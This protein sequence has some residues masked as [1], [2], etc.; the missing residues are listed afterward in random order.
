MSRRPASPKCVGPGPFLLLLMVISGGSMAADAVQGEIRLRP[1]REGV[2]WVGQELEINL[3]LLSTG[4]SFGGQHFNL[5]QVS[6]AYLLQADSNTVK[7][8]EKRDGETWQG[9]RYSFLLYPQ[10]EGRLNIPSFEV[11]F[12]AS[13][14][15][16]QQSVP[17]QFATS[18]LSIEA[19]LPPGASGADLLVTTPDFSLRTEWKPQPSGA[20][21]MQLKVGDA[22]SLIINRQAA[23]VPGMV[24]SPLPEFAIEGLQAYPEAPGVNDRINRGALIGA[25]TD[26]VT[27]ICQREGNYE[28]P[29]VRFQ[30]WDPGRE[31]LHEEISS[32]L[33]FEV[34]P[35]PAYRQAEASAP[36]QSSLISR[37]QLLLAILVLTLLLAAAWKASG[38]ISRQMQ[39]RRERRESGEPWAFRQ[40]IK[41]CSSAT[42]PVAYAAVTLWL[43]RFEP[44]NGS[45]TLLQLAQVSGQSDLYREAEFLQQAVVSGAEPEW[46]GTRL[47]Q[48]LRKLRTST[49]N[50]PGKLYGLAALNPK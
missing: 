19:R 31:V 9:L 17:F 47:G 34:I 42:P 2:V 16:G 23:A 39:H 6:G 1:G 28:I 35:N 18:P 40:A 45:L 11:S 20:Q 46:N 41:A 12:T 5:P 7:L 29:G 43:T 38:F 30:W 4:F 10:R 14:G 36:G 22:L 50:R 32:G 21:D 24:F 48:L 8:T 25:R 27:F 13:A 15:Y 49:Q 3:D 33:K 26:S 44:A 37:R